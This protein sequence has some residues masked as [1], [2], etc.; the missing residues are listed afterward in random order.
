[1]SRYHF[2]LTCDQESR[3][4]EGV[5][6]PTLFDARC[7]AVKMMAEVL[8]TSPERYWENDC[9]RVT[10]ADGAGL[11]LFIVEIRSTDS[12]AIGRR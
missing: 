2:H 1:M 12:A 7:Y 4:D 8:C 5:E 10:V 9:Y 3:D 11:T 6:L